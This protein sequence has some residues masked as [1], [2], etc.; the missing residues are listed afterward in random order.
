MS[1]FETAFAAEDLAAI[2]NRLRTEYGAVDG[3]RRADV[4]VQAR[5]LAFLSRA[6][7]QMLQAVA[8]EMLA[9]TAS[10]LDRHGNFW[11]IFQKPSTAATGTITLPADAGA[12]VSAAAR[13]RRDDGAEYE[14]VA[15]ATAV[16]G[17]ITLSLRAVEVGV[18]GN[19]P[20]GARLSFISPAP[21]VA[22]SAAAGELSGGADI[23]TIE[24]WRARILARVN[25]PPHGGAAHDYVAWA[26]AVP[27]VTRAW[28]MPQWLGIGTVGLAFVMDGRADII[29]TAGDVAI[30]QAYIDDPARRPV[31][32][33]VTVFAPTPKPQDLSIRLR[34]DTPANRAA[35]MAELD[36][37]YRRE[38]APGVS[39]WPSRLSEA[40]SLAAGEFLHEFG[41]AMGEFT[42]AP[43]EIARLG[44]VTWL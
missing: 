5:A 21:G 35:V 22:A 18:G 34:P 26:L 38:A 17:V 16:A 40:I 43:H 6:Q 30:V 4:E 3:L 2:I 7:Q 25:Q 42:C 44:T 13:L 14:T 11:S 8:R 31:T 15:D 28:V 9:S 29:P 32:A 41:S 39:I 37:F 24:E 12:V 20:A 19:A 36:D 33:D 27:G 23:E 1:D 10:F